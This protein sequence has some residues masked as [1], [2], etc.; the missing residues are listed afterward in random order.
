MPGTTDRVV[1]H[2]P[3]DEWAMI[4]RA[5]S[6]DREYLGPAPHQQ[7]LFAADMADQLAAIGKLG[8]RDPPREIG[9]A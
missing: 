7:H 1:D 5:M 3:V 9:A 8:E 6:P 2:E 4:V